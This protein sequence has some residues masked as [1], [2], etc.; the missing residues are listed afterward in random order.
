M[1]I[2]LYT[3]FRRR[4][5]S[6]VKLAAL[7]GIN[8][9]VL[10]RILT[11][12]PGRGKDSRVKIFPHLVTAEIDALGWREEYAAW[13]QKTTGQPLEQSSTGNNV[14]PLPYVQTP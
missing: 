3:S 11:N 2:P 1:N 7:C 8:R 13:W 14:P 5:L 6:Q 10:A 9:S 12:E 4:G